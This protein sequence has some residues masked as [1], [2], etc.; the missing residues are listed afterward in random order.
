MQAFNE[1]KRIWDPANRMNTG[2]V[3]NLE[4]PAYGIT[5]NMRIGPDY[6]PPQ[7]EDAFLLHRRSSTALPG[8][9]CDASAWEPAG[10]KG[11]ERCAPRIW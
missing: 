11:A 8:L 6:H 3:I 7:A 2:K 5:E 4:G 1:F 9:H 10:A